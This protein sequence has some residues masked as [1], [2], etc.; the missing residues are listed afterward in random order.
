MNKLFTLLT[1]LTISTTALAQVGLKINEVDYDQLGT[2]SA[3]YLELFN[4][5]ANAIDLGNYSVLL[6]NGFNGTPYDTITLPTF[7]L[8]PGAFFVICG[9]G[10]FVPN[11]N[12]TMPVYSNMIQNGSPDAIAIIE[13]SSGNIIDAILYEDSTSNPSPYEEGTGVPFVQSDTIVTSP[14]IS[15]GRF[16][17]GADSNDNSADFNTMCFTP[18]A[19]N[20]NGTAN[21]ITSVQG[22]SRLNNTLRVYP[23]PS[24]GISTIDCRGLQNASVSIKNVIGMEIKSV[25]LNGQDFYQCDLSDFPNG[26]YFVKIK[27]GSVEYTQR[28][29]LRR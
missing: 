28:L 25:I 29:V 3:E 23:N 22:I 4:A 12:L 10:G 15:M 19:A 14:G 8:N 17:D 18:G 1:F 20:V 11:C 26:V 27:S 9:N 21:C 2:D 5:D 24:R 6:V 7:T 16:P 13:T